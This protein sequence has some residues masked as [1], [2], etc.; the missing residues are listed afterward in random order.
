MISTCILY[1]FTTIKLADM[2]IF[3]I[4]S[5][6]N[7]TTTILLPTIDYRTQF[8]TGIYRKAGGLWYN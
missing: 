1:D 8:P 5:I 4:F 2:Y 7:L 3:Y 6:G